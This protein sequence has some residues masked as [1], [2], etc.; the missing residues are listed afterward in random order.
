MKAV[1]GEIQRMKELGV[2][3]KV[4]KPTAWYAGMVVVPKA[5]GKVR[6]CVDL[7][8][9]NQSMHRDKHPLLNRYW[10]SLQEPSCLPS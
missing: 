4:N 1:E 7:T 8:Q 10:P 3:A 5:N 6:I 2:L 9:L